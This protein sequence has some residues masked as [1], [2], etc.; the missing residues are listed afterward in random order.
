[1]IQFI[2]IILFFSVNL[3]SVI[4]LTDIEVCHLIKWN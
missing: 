4:F 3:K 2:F 1:M